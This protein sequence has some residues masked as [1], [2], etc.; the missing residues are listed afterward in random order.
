MEPKE[1]LTWKDVYII[2]H[3]GNGNYLSKESKKGRPKWTT[4][5][6]NSYQ[7]DS[8]VIMGFYEAQNNLTLHAEVINI[9][10]GLPIN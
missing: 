10:T 1:K 4:D 8:A 5:K 3:D 9:H 7:W 2:A 6:T